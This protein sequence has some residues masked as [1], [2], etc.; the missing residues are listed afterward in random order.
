[1]PMSREAA[2]GLFAAVE[3]NP[4][5]AEF[6]MHV[7][8]FLPIGV[9]YKAQDRYGP[10]ALMILGSQ[11]IQ[12]TEN[13]SIPRKN[14]KPFPQEKLWLCEIFNQEWLQRCFSKQELADAIEHILAEIKI[15]PLLEEVDPATTL[16]LTAE[17]SFLSEDLY[18]QER[19]HKIDQENEE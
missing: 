16:I 4:A 17:G 10:L 7:L 18:G 1:M 11:V 19:K 13:V 9:R 15:S 5:A 6:F 8:R 3:Y 12:V 14:Q 2:E